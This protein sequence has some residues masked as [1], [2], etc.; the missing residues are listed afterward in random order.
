VPEKDFPA[1][2]KHELRWARTIRALVPIPYAASVLQISLF[3]ALLAACAGGWTGWI[4]FA[5]VLLARYLMA[6]QIDTALRLAKAGE[7]WLFVLRDFCSV[8]I[9]IASFSGNKVD[10]RGQMMH[11]DAGKI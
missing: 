8:L 9:Y 3:W 6:Q 5:A 1:L 10:W 11:A 2:L 4:L 7:A